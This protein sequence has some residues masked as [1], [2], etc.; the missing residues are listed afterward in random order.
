[1]KEDDTCETCEFD[2]ICIACFNCEHEGDE[3]FCGPCRSGGRCQW[4]ER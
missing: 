3:T 4:E 1:M 2:P